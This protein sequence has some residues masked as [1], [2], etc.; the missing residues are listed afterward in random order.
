MQLM[1][2]LFSATS[3]KSEKCFGIFECF[4]DI[5]TFECSKIRKFDI[6]IKKNS[7]QEVGSRKNKK[8]NRQDTRKVKKFA[9]YFLGHDKPVIRHLLVQYGNILLVPDFSVYFPRLKARKILYGKISELVKYF[10]Y[11]TRNRLITIT[12]Q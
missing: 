10:S 2:D 9:E 3:S 7:K 5:R 8:T 11:C 6:R 12:Y 4:L 1:S